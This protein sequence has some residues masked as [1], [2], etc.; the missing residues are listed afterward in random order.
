VTASLSTNKGLSAHRALL[1]VL[2]ETMLLFVVYSVLFVVYNALFV[3][4]NA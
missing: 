2:H 1:C 4:Y 3:V